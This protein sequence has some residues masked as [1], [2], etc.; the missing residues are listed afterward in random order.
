MRIKTLIAALALLAPLISRAPLW[1]DET[2]AAAA[3][4]SDTARSSD[5]ENMT[6]SAT[7][8]FTAAAALFVVSINNGS[9]G[10]AH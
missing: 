1:A 7:A 5:W 10:N 9:S 2:G 6:F 4:S 3:S 8:I